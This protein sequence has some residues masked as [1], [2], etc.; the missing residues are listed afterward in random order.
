LK[1]RN[2]RGDTRQWNFIWIVSC[3]VEHRWSIAWCY[4]AFVMEIRVDC[5]RVAVIRT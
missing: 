1:V 3:E 5:H 4:L 2:T